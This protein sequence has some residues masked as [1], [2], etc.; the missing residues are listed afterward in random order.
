MEFE[1]SGP[2]EESLRAMTAELIT[3]LQLGQPEATDQPLA[4]IARLS[5]D[6]NQFGDQSVACLACAELPLAYARMKQLSTFEYDGILFIH[7]T[8]EHIDAAF[9]FAVGP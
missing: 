5:L 6:E 1:A 8:A 7:T 4:T 2:L 9:N 3:D